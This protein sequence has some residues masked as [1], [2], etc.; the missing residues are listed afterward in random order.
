MWHNNESTD[1]VCLVGGK[2][3]Q[4]DHAQWEKVQQLALV[5]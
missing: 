1:E 2:G 4:T 5:R 3:K